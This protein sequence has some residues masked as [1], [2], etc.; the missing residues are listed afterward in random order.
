V[1]ENKMPTTEEVERAYHSLP[2]TAIVEAYFQGTDSIRH[3][4]V[5]VVEPLLMGQLELDDRQTAIVGTFY[6]IVAWLKALG[7]L[8]CLAHYQAVASGSRALFELL[9]DI[10]LI[11]SDATGKLVKMFH[12][13]PQVE[14]FRSA[15]KLVSYCDRSNNTRIDCTNQREFI[16]LENNMTIDSL[17]VECW[18]TNNKGKPKWP[19]HWSGQTVAE[20]AERLGPYYEEF[21]IE[22]YSFLSWHIHSG[23]TGYAGQSRET[24]ESAF[25]LIHHTI[26]KVVLDATEICAEEMEID[27][28]E[29]LTKPFKSIIEDLRTTTDQILVQKYSELNN[30][31]STSMGEG[32]EGQ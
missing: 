11:Q 31:Q 13:F 24:M 14:K 26:Q 3:F 30:Q 22:F 20:R 17:V 21:Y 19:T 8:N 2:T 12:A 27:K 32:N 15:S 5:K 16:E 18:G 6:R 25:G 10:K 29:N 7:E 9:L 4:I 23:S 28:V 1:K